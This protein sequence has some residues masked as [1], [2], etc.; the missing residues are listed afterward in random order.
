MRNVIPMFA[1]TGH[2]TRKELETEIE[3]FKKAGIGSV[4]I[5]PRSGCLVPYMSEEWF[6]LIGDAIA[7]CEQA[8]VKIW[9]YDEFNW[10]SG[11][12]GGAVMAESTQNWAKKIVLTE[13]GLEIVSDKRFPDLL[14]ENAVHTFIRL[15]HDKYFERFEEKF[16]SVIVG[17]FTDEPC[18]CYHV[19]RTE[20]IVYYTGM[21][22]DY[23]AKTG[24]DFFEDVIAYYQ[25]QPYEGFMQA[26]FA[27]LTHRMKENYI[28]KIADW[29][30]AHNIMLTGH[31][32]AD[33]TVMQGTWDSGDTL[34]VLERIH[35]PGI[36]DI[37]TRMGDDVLV[38]FA[39]IDA[40]KR[41]TGKPTMIELFALGPCDMSYNRKRRSLYMSAAHGIDHYFI[42][43]A[44]LSMTGNY[45]KLRNYF[46]PESAMA[47]DYEKTAL[48]CKEAEYAACLA[49]KESTPDVYIRYPR[50][51]MLA[52]LNHGR[53]E[54]LKA[55][56]ILLKALR[57]IVNAQR[58]FAFAD[59]DAKNALDIRPDGVYFAGKKIE[60][61]AFLSD[62]PARDVYVTENGNLA[63]NVFVK[64][65]KDG[66]FLICDLEERTNS[67]DVEIHAFGKVYKKTFYPMQ[68]V[69]SK[70]LSDWESIP[71]QPDWTVEF[72][73]G[74]YRPLLW[75]KQVFEATSDLKLR[76]V[77][78]N[79]PKALPVL[80]DGKEIKAELPCDILGH[81]ADGLYRMSEEITLSAGK[82]TLECP[83]QKEERFYLPICILL[84]AFES[85]G[86][87]LNP[88]NNKKNKAYF[89]GKATA[90]TTLFVPQ[91]AKAIRFE[92]DTLYTKVYADGAF[93]GA[94]AE[95]S[96]RL[97]LPDQIKGK[98]VSFVFEQITTMAPLFG[99]INTKYCD[100]MNQTPAWNIG[101]GVTATPRGLGKIEFLK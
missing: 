77:V 69:L 18:F 78:R 33:T 64:V 37:I 45:H 43:V 40:V 5:Y 19:E 66:T 97:M 70:E 17:M 24:R 72:E 21:E 60:L 23:R 44:Q 73:K 48:F 11:G 52:C 90:S 16:G 67:R 88:K 87:V 3:L 9:L 49:N 53:K 7:V 38:A 46:N 63:K 59:A 93:L 65:Y 1:L 94:A 47:P 83:A 74:V 50:D 35:M 14:D 76:F 91:D 6:T 26:V 62:L 20:E 99:S 101:W 42:A 79:Y 27:L 10:P 89:Y 92:T 95:N 41:K 30:K 56:E 32:L 80:L 82:H 13:N 100:E 36:D 22:Q 81:G 28:G 54:A 34:S 55:E 51:N 96:A 2:P 86:D 31:L 98:S 84:G 4:M 25:K 12:C 57:A 15:T 71:V 58:T 75:E 29:C 39:H 8:D 85:N 68:T 61:E